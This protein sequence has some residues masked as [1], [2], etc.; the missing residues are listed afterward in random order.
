M[1]TELPTATIVFTGGAWAW[2][3]AGLALLGGLLTIVGYRRRGL[4]HKAM[5]PLVLRLAALGLLAVSLA[6]PAWVGE[7]V[8]P[9]ANIVAVVADNSVGLQIKEG[10]ARQTRAEELS[11]LLATSPGEQADWLATIEE[12]F[13]LR[14]FALDAR[15][16]PEWGDLMRSTME[17]HRP[18][19]ARP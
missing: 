3:G 6:E 11:A 8:E 2:A 10:G 13:Q 7:E 16:Q 1:M 12:T 19:L 15:L 9:G 4:R 5:F 14:R 17:E 18:R